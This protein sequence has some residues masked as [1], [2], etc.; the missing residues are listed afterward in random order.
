MEILIGV[1][2]AATL[3]LLGVCAIVLALSRRKKHQTIST[4]IFKNPFGVAVNVKDIFMNLSPHNNNNNNSGNT[5]GVG[6]NRHITENPLP[7]GEQM[8]SDSFTSD[9][10]DK[11]NHNVIYETPLLARKDYETIRSTK[12]RYNNIVSDWILCN[13]L[14]LRIWIILYPGV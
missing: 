10:Y 7:I 8:R 12:G 14:N 3:I 2:T 1:L 13:T 6:N 4:S 11:S 9:G 5:A